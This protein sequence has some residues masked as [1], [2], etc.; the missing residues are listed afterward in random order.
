MPRKKT[1]FEL[2]PDEYERHRSGHLERRRQAIVRDALHDVPHGGRVLELGSGTGGV[3]AELAAERPDASFV[4]VDIEQKMVDYAQATHAQANVRF[5]CADPST[6]PVLPDD[7]CDFVVSVDVLHHVGDLHRF[8]RTV[9][10]LLRP[11]GRWLVIEPNSVHPYV[12]LSQER[13]RRAGVGEDHFRRRVAEPLFRA[14]GLTIAQRRFA[15]FFPGWLE[16]VPRQVAWI[17]PL[18]ERFRLLGGS[19]VY[20]LARPAGRSLTES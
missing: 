16:H 5:V 4:G 7:S 11:G 17:E 20:L 1:H 2:T 3:L 13:M 9:S 15:L 8:V 19:V 18:L 10:R 6:T 14:A 12:F